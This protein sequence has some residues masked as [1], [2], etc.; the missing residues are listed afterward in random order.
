MSVFI[1]GFYV[2]KSNGDENAPHH[3]V[4]TITQFA[5]KFT[6]QFSWVCLELDLQIP[7]TSY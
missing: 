6:Y 1:D 5:T 3:L 4:K 2:I 7:E